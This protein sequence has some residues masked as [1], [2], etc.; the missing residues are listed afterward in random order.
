MGLRE[1][2]IC[3][4]DLHVMEPP[5]LWERYID[6]A[7]RHAAP[8]G[9]SEIPR[10]MR[11]RVK[12]RVVLR[13]GATRPMHVDGRK[14]GW[15][16]DH[17]TVYAESEARG[18]DPES[19]IRRHGRRGTRPRR[20]LPVARLVRPRHRFVR[21][22]RRRRT[23]ARVR[24]GHRPRLQRLA[25]GLLRSRPRPDVRR[26]DGR[27]PRRLRRGRG[28]PAVRGGARLQGDL[29]GAGGGE[30]AAVAPRSLTT[31][32]GRRSNGSASP[33]PSTVAARPTSRR[34]SG[35]RC[36]TG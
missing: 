32:C 7:Y 28:S 19:Q 3:D 11:V 13:L 8:R 14:T 16:K 9:L 18:W 5:D 26:R 22:D 34:T 24:N 10:D 35:S 27:A 4:S 17:D 33:W 36:W 1:H 20:A 15:Q 6:P 2:V 30:P 29:P 31:R 12:N 25:Q 21:A 23:G